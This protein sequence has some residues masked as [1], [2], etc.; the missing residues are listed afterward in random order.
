MKQKSFLLTLI[1]SA[2]LAIS[3]ASAAIVLSTDFDNSGVTSGDMTGIVWTENGL[4]APTTLGASANIRTGLGG[5]VDAEGGY[6]SGDQ[7]VKGST[8]ASP[9]WSTTWSITVGANDVDLS[10]IVLASAEA[11]SSGSLDAGN[12]SSNINLTI[13]GTTID[14]TE[15]R[16]GNT[17]PVDLTYLTP[18]T[19]DA[20]AS[21][22]VTFTV[23]ENS[24]Q[25]HFE[26]FDSV[27]FN[28]DV[29]PEPSATLLG[30]LGL[31]AL[32][33]RRRA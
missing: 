28:G 11:N 12:G 19:L 4:T 30:A 8:E 18:V 14:L 7:N 24:S 27:T 21:Y 15:I 1:T 29:I 10:S 33:R 9:A 23:W 3:N 31:L 6:F 32:L 16:S 2:V 13:A 22:D 20:S 17:T 26:G 25:G 5:D